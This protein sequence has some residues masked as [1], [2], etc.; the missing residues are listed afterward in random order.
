MTNTI[1]PKK[2]LKKDSY[3]TYIISGRSIKATTIDINRR[4]KEKINPFSP[5]SNYL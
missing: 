2:A 3:K 4:K 1:N 5:L